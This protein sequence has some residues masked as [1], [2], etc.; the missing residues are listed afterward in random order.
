M[1]E[2]SVPVWKAGAIFE[3]GFSFRKPLSERYSCTTDV[4]Y[5]VETHRKKC[6]LYTL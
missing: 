5:T 6:L 2:V 4:I 3:R 1:S